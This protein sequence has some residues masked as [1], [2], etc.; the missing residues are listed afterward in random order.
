[1][2]DKNLKKVKKTALIIVA[3]P[4]DE[5][6]WSG[7]TIL[8]HQTWEWFIV[9]LCRSKDPD[10]APK[11]FKA[12]KILFAEGAMGDLNDEPEQ[13]PLNE[14][15]VET[16][17]LDLLPI[18]HFDLMI[19][20]NPEGEYTRHIRHEEIGKAVIKLWNTNRIAANEYWAFAYEDGHKQY[21]PR[22]DENA[23]MH[24][25]LTKKIWQEKYKIITETYGFKADSWEAKTTPKAESFWH[26]TKPIDAL[27]WKN[28]VAGRR[29]GRLEWL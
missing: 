22:P 14:S 26:F 3:H 29:S 28:E 2:A 9:S 6:L 16:A 23:G 12:L 25:I 24:T 8:S 20:H 18:K 1:M 10:R 4:D 11:F 21:L 7:G 5:T 17:I 13:K 27:N 19:S 15:E